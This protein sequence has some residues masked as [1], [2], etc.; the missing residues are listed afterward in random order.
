VRE[1]W[2]DVQRAEF[3]D[4]VSGHLLGG[5]TGEVLEKAFEYWKNVDG[6]TG[7]LIEANVRAGT[8]GDNPGRMPGLAKT[9]AAAPIVETDTNAG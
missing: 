3:V 5:V 6:E 9:E 1:V 2:N 8:G 4:N 7:K